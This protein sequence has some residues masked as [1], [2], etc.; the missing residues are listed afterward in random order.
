M[1]KLLTLLFLLLLAWLA[2]GTW[3]YARDC[4]ESEPFATMGIP[5][6]L[7]FMN[8]P[9]AAIVAKE[10]I[11]VEPIVKPII[12][13]PLQ[14]SDGADLNIRLS[15]NVVFGES[16]QKANISGEVQN[17]YDKLAKYLIEN[18]EKTLTLTGH[19]ATK[20]Q[21]GTSFPNLGLARANEIKDSPA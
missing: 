14:I 2:A 18:P 8:Q 17:A 21:N 13:V 20:E 12:A 11:K 3:Y 10:E 15:E 5:Y 19:Y 7:P 1:K 9:K 6:T 4:G 16:K